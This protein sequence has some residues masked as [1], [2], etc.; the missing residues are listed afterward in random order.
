MWC[1]ICVCV[2]GVFVCMYGLWCVCVCVYECVYLWRPEINTR[3][4]SQLLSFTSF[5]ETLSLMEFG[6]HLLG[7][8]AGQRTPGIHLSQL[9]ST[10]V[11]EVTDISHI[12]LLCER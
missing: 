6:T 7:R 11:T 10:G 2:C 5:F 9:P 3:Y 1:G 12:A 4:L 8:L